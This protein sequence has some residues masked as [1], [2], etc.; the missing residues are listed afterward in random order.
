MRAFHLGI[1]LGGRASIVR[2]SC[3]SRPFNGVPKAFVPARSVRWQS[4]DNG[5]VKPPQWTPHPLNAQLPPQDGPSLAS[6]P[7]KVKTQTHTAYI[8]LGSNLGDRI[9]WIEKACNLMS[10]RS[11]RVKRTSS[12]WETAPM[13]V[14]NQE[15]FINGACEV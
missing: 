10:E 15:N 7:P 4:S 3:C 12:L 6:I 11:I 2:N 9:G 5:H 1:R 14:T 8:A 13:Y